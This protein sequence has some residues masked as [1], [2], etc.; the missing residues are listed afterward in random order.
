MEGLK[1]NKKKLIS[2]ENAKTLV[3]LLILVFLFDFFLFAAPVLANNAVEAEELE[4]ILADK[5]QIVP[6]VNNLPENNDWQAKYMAD[7]TITA[8]NSE[9]GQC[10]DS[11]CITANGFNVCKHGIEDTIAANFLTFGTKVRI[12]A[13]FGDRI[14]I[15]RD[16]MN[17]RYSSRVD[18]WMLEKQD[19]KKFG[20]KRAVIE[21]LE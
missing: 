16:R 11:P 8:Y 15:V 21:V 12:P 5:K 14:F 2:P 13:L 9:V 3:L 10:D 19:A 17:E 20:V 18:V 1:R 7:H 4:Q 6:N